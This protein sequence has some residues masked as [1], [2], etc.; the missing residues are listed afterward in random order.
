MKARAYGSICRALKKLADMALPGCNSFVLKCYT[1]ARRKK[2]TLISK[3]T[4][5][6]LYGAHYM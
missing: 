5:G 3:K 2:A 1:A 6:F 4:F